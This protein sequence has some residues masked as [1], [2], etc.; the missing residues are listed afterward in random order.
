VRDLN[1]AG[2]K[3]NSDQLVVGERQIHV[4]DSL[5]GFFAKADETDRRSVDGF[6]D[7]SNGSVFRIRRIKP[8]PSKFRRAQS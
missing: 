2:K 3:A 5:S 1:R 7:S 4:E 8:L 6:C